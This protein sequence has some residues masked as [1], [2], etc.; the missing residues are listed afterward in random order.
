M[1]TASLNTSALPAIG[2][3]LWPA[4]LLVIGPWAIRQVRPKP[5]RRK[6]RRS[7]ARQLSLS[8]DNHIRSVE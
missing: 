4:G 6:P 7:A 8:L 1:T 3:P 5:E 2:G